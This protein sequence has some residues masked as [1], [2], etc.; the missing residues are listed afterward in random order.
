MRLII[1]SLLV[2]ISVLPVVSEAQSGDF[3]DVNILNFRPTTDPWGIFTADTSSRLNHLQWHAGAMASYVN[4]P[5]TLALNGDNLS[6]PVAHQ[7]LFDLTAAVG[8][9]KSFQVGV[10]LPLV[11]YQASSGDL[12]SLAGSGDLSTFALGD[13][14]IIPKWV[15]LERSRFGVGVALL[16]AFSI[17]TATS[18]S[19]AGD[20][21]LTFEPRVAVDYKIAGVLLVANLGYRFRKAVSVGD[22]MVNDEIYFSLGAQYPLR[23]Q[24]TLMAELYGAIG[25]TDSPR[26]SDSGVDM[27]EV[28]LEL[29]AGARYLHE[30]GIALTAGLGVGVTEGYGTPRVRIFAGVGY[31]PPV[32][33]TEGVKDTD[34]D[35]I[36][37]SVDQC[38]LEPED[39]NGFEDEDGCPDANKDTDKDGIPDIKDKCPKDPEDKNGFEDEDGC[40]DAHKDTDKDGIPD[41][42]DKCPTVPEDKNGFEDEDG[43]PDANKDTDKDGIPDYKDKCP[44]DPEDKDGFQDEDGCPDPDND[45][46]GFCDPND[47]IQ[48]N[49]SKYKSICKGKDQCPNEKE[50]INGVKDDDGCPDE[51]KE[52]AK[53]TKGSI[54]IMNKIYFGSGSA[55][56]LRKSYKILDIVVSILK[57]HTRIELLEV[58]GHTDDVGVDS[59]N[60]KLSES[61]AKS[62]MKYL[63]SKG[64]SASRLTSRGFGEATPVENCVGKKRFALENCRGKNR[65][66]EF[67]ITR[68]KENSK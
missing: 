43:C 17:P 48:K 50:T 60:M 23:K 25:V 22:L 14:R 44:N 53:I 38:P 57:T 37:D 20:A 11:A 31:L 26:D 19:S 39:K 7:I 68:I 28:P 58:Q 49:L 35:G 2:F 27:A 40:P 59:K 16:P 10:H 21:S 6:A 67:K 52:L 47:T 13:L 64:I 56:L 5:L 3:R 4:N 8:I 46:D 15:A 45:G 36:P 33:K 61:R 51:G 34:K 18:G 1:A 63:V 30:K 66:V 54:V 29:V 42:K 12:S 24:I 62:V 9:Y 65:R 55:V 41:Y 32:K